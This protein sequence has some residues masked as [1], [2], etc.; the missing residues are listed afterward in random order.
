MS[1]VYNSFA[2]RSAAKD[3]F[4]AD[5]RLTA[6]AALAV[7]N[8]LPFELHLRFVRLGYLARL[9]NHGPNCL[10]VALDVLS[11]QP[12]SFAKLI[13]VDLVWNFERRGKY[14]GMPDPLASLPVAISWVSECQ[15]RWRKLLFRSR[16]A[17]TSHLSLVSFGDWWQDLMLKECNGRAFPDRVGVKPLP[18]GDGKFLQ[19]WCG[20]TCSNYAK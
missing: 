12:F 13:K 18:A 16:V 17:V 15:M 3:F 11:P 20:Y 1:S 7:C 19:C 6:N 14:Y 4:S 9:A 8:A 2:R 5:N 10:L